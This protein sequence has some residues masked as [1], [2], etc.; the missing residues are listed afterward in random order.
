MLTVDCWLQIALRCKKIKEV[1]RLSISCTEIYTGFDSYDVYRKKFDRDFPGK[2]YHTWWSP[3][4]NYTLQYKY[5]GVMYSL[6][7][8]DETNNVDHMFYKFD[9]GR[10]RI[11]GLSSWITNCSDTYQL[12]KTDLN[13][14]GLY[15]VYIAYDSIECGGSALK[16]IGTYQ[17]KIEVKD[18]IR[19]FYTGKS[20]QFYFIVVQLDTMCF[21]FHFKE[22]NISKY[23]I[24]HVKDNIETMKGFAEFQ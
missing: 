21:E 17:T 2:I 12:V 6:I 20:G 11:L 4:E 16:H 3:L 10:K 7:G 5:E 14:P 19:S 23:W 1:R 8:L 22:H 9:L 13:N 15:A 24:F 18:E